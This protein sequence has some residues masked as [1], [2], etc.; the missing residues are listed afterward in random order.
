[1]IENYMI[2]KCYFQKKKLGKMV[3]IYLKF[4]CLVLSNVS[5]IS[6]ICGF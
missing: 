4:K 6:V 5:L 2:Q 1:M 3:H